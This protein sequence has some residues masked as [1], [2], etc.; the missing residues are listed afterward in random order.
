MSNWSNWK[1]MPSPQTCRQIE[2]PDGPGVYQI[3]HRMT[4]QFIQFGIGVECRKRMKSLF[5]E[6]YG[7]GKRNNSYKRDYVFSNWQVLEYRTLPTGTRE[8]AKQIEDEIKAQNN[9]MFNT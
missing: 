9:H 2:G 4:K 3:R 1:P 6:P 8:E 5:P 7:S